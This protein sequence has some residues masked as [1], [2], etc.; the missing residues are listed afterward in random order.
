M[1][2]SHKVDTADGIRAAQRKQEVHDAHYILFDWDKKDP[3]CAY[4]QDP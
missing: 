2:V 4:R 3:F 1:S